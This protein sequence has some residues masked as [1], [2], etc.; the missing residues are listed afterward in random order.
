VILNACSVT[1]V[2]PPLVSQL[3]FQYLA[4]I[5]LF[6]EALI[7]QVD[8]AAAATSSQ[9]AFVFTSEQGKPFSTDQ[10]SAAIK[11]QAEKASTV[12]LTVVS[13]R[14]AA[15]AIAK[16]FIPAIAR[17]FDLY[18]LVDRKENPQL[19]IAKQAE[20]TLQTLTDSYI[21]DQAFP[22]YLQPELLEQYKKVSAYWHQ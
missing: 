15:L 7:H 14:Q 2:L 8:Q 18:Y 19:G 1:Q 17:Y 22:T 11:E 20:Y 16:Y 9:D 3:F 10:I 4:Y 5:Q 13:Y 6:A 12:S 21:L